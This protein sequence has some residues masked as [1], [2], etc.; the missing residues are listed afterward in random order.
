MYTFSADFP[1]DALSSAL[2]VAHF[3]VK[4]YHEQNKSNAV[5][6]NHGQIIFGDAVEQP[7]HNAGIHGQCPQQADVAGL[8]G[9]DD[10]ESLGK[11]RQSGYDS[12]G[13]A[14]VLVFMHHDRV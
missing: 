5:G 9:S 2:S 4:N 14:K 8:A 3:A 13:I 10:S 1:L 6:A 12:G 11:K 7:E